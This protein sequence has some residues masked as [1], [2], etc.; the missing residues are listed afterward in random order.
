MSRRKPS[1]AACWW[2]AST[3][4]RRATLPLAIRLV[5][6]MSEV[7]SRAIVS[8]SARV[9][10]NVRIGAFAVVGDGVD[11]GDD[12]VLEPHAVVRGPARVGRKNVFDSF[13]SVGG[14]PQ[15]LKFGGEHTEIVIGDASRFLE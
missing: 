8:A 9:G 2:T 15:D 11:L 14:D 7:D 10:Q 4:P 1:C 6:A 5:C 13:C 12:C 3:E